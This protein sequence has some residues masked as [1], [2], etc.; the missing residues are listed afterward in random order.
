MDRLLRHTP[1]NKETKRGLGTLEKADQVLAIIHEWQTRQLEHSFAQGED[2]NISSPKVAFPKRESVML[3][4]WG[5]E[6][7]SWVRFVSLQAQVHW[8]LP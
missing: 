4:A 5:T 7:E 1:F 6:L 3:G 2:G 8:L